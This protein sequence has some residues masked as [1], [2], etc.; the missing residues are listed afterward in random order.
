MRAIFPAVFIV[1]LQ[2]CPSDPLPTLRNQRLPGSLNID[3]D[4]LSAAG[5]R[6]AHEDA[7][8]RRRLRFHRVLDPNYVMS[9]TRAFA[10]ANRIAAGEVSLSRLVDVG[11]VLFEHEF[12]ESEGM[13]PEFQRFGGPDSHSCRACHWRG[14]TG[15]AGG[16]S[17]NSFVHGDGIGAMDGDARNP[18][19]LDGLGLVQILAKEMTEDLHRLRDELI[20]KA[21]A[22]QSKTSVAL[23]SKG[24]RF[25]TLSSDSEGVLNASNVDGV[26]LDLNVKPF[27]WKGTTVSLR[28]FV[29]ES[30]REHMKVMD[31]DLSEGQITAIILFLATQPLPI[32]R[33]PVSV[34]DVL[35]P[36]DGQAP[37]KAT[38]Y[39]SD[40]H[41]GQE[42]F[43]RIGC[44]SCHLSQ[45]V[46]KD[47]LFTTWSRESNT[48]LEIDLAQQ[49]NLP[50]DSELGGYVVNLFSDLKR[51]DLGAANQAVIDDASLWAVGCL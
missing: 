11:R 39:E 13:A 15:G 51:H 42:T 4:G 24:V 1:V 26:D 21:R 46:L 31:G 10:D 3:R 19:A 9:K 33:A 34:A 7:L 37:I 41:R 18:L 43:E 16:L 27:R 2:A 40:W 23:V 50:F 38:V 17:D 44:G 5:A 25:G 12:S 35:Q 36:F 22:S 45:M 28:D 48:L 29:E 47:S 32:L 14:G 20:A 30:F 8:L 49:F 6:Q